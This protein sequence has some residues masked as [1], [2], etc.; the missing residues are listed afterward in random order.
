MSEGPFA[1]LEGCL[2]LLGQIIIV[3]RLFFAQYFEP[4]IVYIFSFLVE[5]TLWQSEKHRSAKNDVFSIL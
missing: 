3:L 5:I 4:S 2:C 1:P